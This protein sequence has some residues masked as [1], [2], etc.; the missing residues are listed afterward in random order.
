VAAT[1][2]AGCAVTDVNYKIR[3]AFTAL[4]VP[5][6]GSV[7]RVSI[8]VIVVSAAYY[9]SDEASGAP[10]VQHLHLKYD[11]NHKH[12]F[13]GTFVK[14]ETANNNQYLALHVHVSTQVAEV[15]FSSF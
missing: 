4:H 13:G 14:S 8:V 3:L 1:V 15:F 10:F 11:I 6:K 7:N 5:R 9:S 2:K 12:F